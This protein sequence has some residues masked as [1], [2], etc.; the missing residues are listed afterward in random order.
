[1]G[2][3]N[4][5][6]GDKSSFALSARANR[7]AEGCPTSGTT[8]PKEEN[9][10]RIAA[11]VAPPQQQQDDVFLTAE[12]VNPQSPSISI[13]NPSKDVVEH[14]L[15]SM[16]AIRTSDLCFF[17]FATQSIDY[18]KAESRSSN[19]AMELA[20]MPKNLDGCDGGTLAEGDELT[21]SVSVD[22]AHCSIHTYIIHLVWKQSGWYC[23]SGMKAGYIVPK[24]MSKNGRQAYVDLLTGPRFADKQIAIK[25]Q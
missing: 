23:E 14:V 10:Y 24:D 7:K 5:D 4:H 9:S 18:I 16:V 15:W 11:P 19:Y 2:Q 17:G 20:T 25:P 1:M 6:R 13:Y 22:C 3:D 21:G 8:V 12:F